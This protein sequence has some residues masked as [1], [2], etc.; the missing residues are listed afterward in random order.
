MADK[1]VAILQSNYIPWKG[2]FDIIH[3]VDLFV[4]YDDLQFTKNDWRN[5][6]KIKTANGLQWLSIPVG[7]D[8]NRLICEVALA[9]P[10]WQ[11][12]HWET[13]RQQYGKCPHFARYRPFFEALYL[14][15]EWGNLS[16]LNHHLI[17][18][19][20]TDLLGMKTTFQD[21]RQYE[22]SGQ[23]LERLLNLVA[24]TGATEYVSGPA[25]KDYIDAQRFVE[26]QVQLIW[27]DYSGYPAYQQPHPPFEHGVSI[28][29]L[30]F[31]AGPDAPWY[32]WG[33]REGPLS[34]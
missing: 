28:L 20:S 7:T 11:K 33:W 30:L 31:N 6:N 8:K 5:R 19:I 3:D 2:Y 1:R 25:A 4:F 24:Q 18:A 9:D 34:P 29:D 21:S 27:K 10:A 22:L 15:R 13:L 14:G 26:M 17:R 16:E 23:K 12:R 32:I